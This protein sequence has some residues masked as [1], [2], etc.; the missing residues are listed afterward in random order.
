MWI[1]T[2]KQSLERINRIMQECKI[3]DFAEA[4]AKPKKP[5]GGKPKCLNGISQRE[6]RNEQTL[7]KLRAEAQ[8]S[9]L[10]QSR[11]EKK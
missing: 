9:K 6:E 5:K 7:K 10:R 2:I 11:Q 3:I 8:A 4:K 1:L